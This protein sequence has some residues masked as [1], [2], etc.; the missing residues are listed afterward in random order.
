MT[1]TPIPGGWTEEQVRIAN[2]ALDLVR[3]A[4][5]YV[6]LDQID[7][8]A[9]DAVQDPYWAEVWPASREMAEFVLRREWEADTPTLE[10]G[11]GV[12]LV[13]LAALTRG[14]DVT[15]SDLHQLAVD[16]AA[17]NARRNGYRNVQRLPL[18]WS[19]PVGQG[20]RFPL[21]LAADVLYE[22]NLHAPL[23]ASL[24]VMLA[25]GGVCWIGDP[26][27]SSAQHLLTLAEEGG[28]RVRI[29]NRDEKELAA[30]V[31]NEF[32]LFQLTRD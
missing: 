26:G 4:D 8:C 9:D 2:V 11:C 20:Y 22:R 15:F 21:I 7:E 14:L 1:Q 6:F 16:T 31:R 30:L 32:Q 25:E 5:P 29:V 24:D 17:E 23:L 3:P 27:R 19:K 13:G 28:F 12:G 18:D 10:L